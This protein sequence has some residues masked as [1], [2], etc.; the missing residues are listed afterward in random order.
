MFRCTQYHRLYRVSSESWDTF[1]VHHSSDIVGLQELVKETLKITISKSPEVLQTTTI[2]PG[3][4]KRRAGKFVAGWAAMGAT[5]EQ[6]GIPW[7]ATLAYPP[8]NNAG[9]ESIRI[10]SSWKKNE[11]SKKSNE[12][13]RFSQQAQSYGES[14]KL[15]LTRLPVAC[16]PITFYLI[17]II[18]NK[19]HIK[20]VEKIYDTINK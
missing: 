15:S 13:F 11:K 3:F 16:K 10:Y 18:K 2:G 7:A 17:V 4:L 8:Q 19:F 6:N 9:V 1:C 14:L 20:K 12:V 5:E